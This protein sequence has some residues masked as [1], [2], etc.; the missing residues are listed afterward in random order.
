[1]KFSKKNDCPTCRTNF[2]YL[3][4]VNG[5][6]NLSFNI[7]YDI[8]NKHILNTYKNIKCNYTFKK[9]KNK[10]KTCNKNCK[11]G[12]YKCNLHISKN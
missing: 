11:L 10:G 8:N 4:T 3:P 5:L 1:M 7:H 12:F 2:K 9:G 6:N